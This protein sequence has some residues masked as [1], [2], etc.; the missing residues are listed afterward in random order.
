MHKC[1]GDSVKMIVALKKFYL[2]KGSLSTARPLN[3][4]VIPN[5]SFFS[6]AARLTWSL[7]ERCLICFL[8]ISYLSVFLLMLL[9]QRANWLVYVKVARWDVN[10]ALFGRLRSFLSCLSI[11]CCPRPSFDSSFSS[12]ISKRSVCRI[13]YELHFS[14][15][16]PALARR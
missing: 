13:L 5:L 10:D 4:L 9:S 8:S 2:T 6:D 15:C 7:L 11:P 1:S 12:Q 3:P 16:V 14:E